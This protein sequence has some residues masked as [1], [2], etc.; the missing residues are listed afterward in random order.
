MSMTR[1]AGIALALP[2]ALTALTGA[3][4]NPTLTYHGHFDD[5]V[6]RTGGC[7]FDDGIPFTGVWTVRV[8]DPTGKIAWLN[9]QSRMDWGGR[10]TMF[11]FEHESAVLTSAS[12]SGFSAYTTSELW[13]MPG[14]KV[15][16]FTLDGVGRFVYQYHD[17][18]TGC[19]IDFTGHQIS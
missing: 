9:F 17:K 12:R 2:V 5:Y 18:E 1:T 15:L 19:V 6:V 11:M 13:G 10:P 7:H 4:A 14:D 3:G 8:P 16:T